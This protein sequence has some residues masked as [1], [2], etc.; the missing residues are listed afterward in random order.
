[1]NDEIFCRIGC[2]AYLVDRTADCG[3]AISSPTA[4]G[5]SKMARNP[6]PRGLHRGALVVERLVRFIADIDI[7]ATIVWY[8]I[9]QVIAAIGLAPAA[10]GFATKTFSHVPEFVIALYKISIIYAILSVPLWVLLGTYLWASNR[11]RRRTKECAA[12][13]HVLADENARS[14]VLLWHRLDRLIYKIREKLQKDNVPE[15]TQTPIS[16]SVASALQTAI[17]KIESN[18]AMNL[19]KAKTLLDDYVGAGSSIALFT[20]EPASEGRSGDGI[21][22]FAADAEGR[23]KWVEFETLDANPIAAYLLENEA[24]IF[25]TN[26]LGKEQLYSLRSRVLANAKGVTAV[27]ILS[28]P[29]GNFHAL[30]AKIGIVYIKNETFGLKNDWIADFALELAARF[31]VMI[32]VFEHI[33]RHLISLGVD[34]PESEIP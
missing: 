5:K 11:K 17:H 13:L 31:S 29:T 25:Q 26:D 21:R 30:D 7:V 2:G 28:R 3:P 14:D 12:G 32:N 22:L 9:G 1:M 34:D 10:T 24:N 4:S 20:A 15:E 6:D 18:V 33:R 23:A 16:Y 8:T 19:E 27:A